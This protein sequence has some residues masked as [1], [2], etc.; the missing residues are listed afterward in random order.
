MKQEVGIKKWAEIY[1]IMYFLYRF[2]YYKY[3]M[4]LFL[5]VDFFYILYVIYMKL[6]WIYGCQELNIFIWSAILMLF[7]KFVYMN[8]SRHT[9]LKKL[10]IFV[11]FC[12]D[13]LKLFHNH[14]GFFFVCT[15]IWTLLH[16]NNIK[17]PL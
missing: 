13:L 10:L 3:Y 6:F 14:L 17:G 2:V 15:T 8:Q 7:Y 1:I 11:C 5:I 12:M 9:D 4:V 16:N